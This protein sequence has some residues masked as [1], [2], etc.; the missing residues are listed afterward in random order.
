MNFRRKLLVVG[1]VALAGLVSMAGAAGAGG[2]PLSTDLIGAEEVPGPGDPN[3]TGQIDLTLNQGQGEICF[4]LSWSDIDGTVN[5][6]HIHLA[7]AGVAGGVVV[8]LPLTTSAGTGESSG[9]VD[10]DQDLIKAIRQDPSAYYVNVHSLPS[11]GPGA[12]RGQLG[13]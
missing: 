2:R 10:V 7:P 3:A 5:A 12:V 13:D 4:D 9:C 6:A 8:P 1:A 11:F